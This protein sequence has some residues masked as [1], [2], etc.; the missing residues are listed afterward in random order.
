MQQKH[1]IIG[2]GVAIAIALGIGLMRP[3]PKASSEPSSARSLWSDER[4]RWLRLGICLSGTP[5]QHSFVFGGLFGTEETCA[6]DDN[7]A[8]MTWE[9]FPVGVQ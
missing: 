2:A 4:L 5:C 7:T 1:I 8:Y 3:P 9:C 6:R